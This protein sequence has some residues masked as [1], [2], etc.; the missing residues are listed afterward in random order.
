MIHT[1]SNC[2]KNPLHSAKEIQ[3]PLQCPLAPYSHTSSNGIIHKAHTKITKAVKS[4]PAKIFMV[5]LTHRY[6]R[7][8][9]I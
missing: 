9:Y 7:L 5:I 1:L 4:R 2:L 8:F 3:R 6:C